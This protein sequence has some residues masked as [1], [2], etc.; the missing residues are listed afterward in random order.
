E[1][2]RHYGE[3]WLA[4]IDR[5]NRSPPASWPTLEEYHPLTLEQEALVDA[6]LALVRLRASDH[7]VA[8]TVLASRKEVESLV[9]GKHDCVLLSGWRREVVGLA[10]QAFMA[11]EL[12]RATDEGKLVFTQVSGFI[13]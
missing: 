2:I 10:L 13:A 9:R 4:C 7:G 6:M 11:G 1:M 12:V 3:A 8:S 5:A